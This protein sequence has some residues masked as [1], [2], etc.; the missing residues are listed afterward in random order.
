VLLHSHKPKHPEWGVLVT[1]VGY[2][3]IV[4][5]LVGGSELVGWSYGVR[6]SARYTVIVGRKAYCVHGNSVIS[7]G[8]SVYSDYKGEGFR[9]AFT[10]SKDAICVFVRS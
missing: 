7:S 4:N 2:V 1:L 8:C 3:L 5:E 10:D 6:C 9:A